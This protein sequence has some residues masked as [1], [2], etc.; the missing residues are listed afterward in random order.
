MSSANTITESVKPE[1]L[2]AMVKA[3]KEFGRYPIDV[4][5]LLADV[6]DTP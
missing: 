4:P 2:L 6:G 5:K 3:T 1:N